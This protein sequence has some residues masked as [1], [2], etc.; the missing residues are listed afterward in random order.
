VI[1]GVAAAGA[2]ALGLEA[3][4]ILALLAAVPTGGPI[5]MTADGTLFEE[6]TKGTL[7]W[8]PV[9]CALKAA[10]ISMTVTERFVMA[11][12][13]AATTAA[14]SAWAEATLMLMTLLAVAVAF[15]AIAPGAVTGMSTAGTKLIFGIAGGVAFL[16]VEVAPD[17]AAALP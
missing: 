17:A 14:W 4:E 2:T 8:V 7:L 13:L 3:F 11:L 9:A 16:A 6:V 5:T 15:E 12:A 1:V 10:L